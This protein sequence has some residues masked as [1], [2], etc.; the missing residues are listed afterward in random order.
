MRRPSAKV[1]VQVAVEGGRFLPCPQRKDRASIAVEV[2]RSRCRHAR[3]C[4][5][6]QAWLRPPLELG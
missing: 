6:Y 5:V 4:A 2:C 1:L 3:R